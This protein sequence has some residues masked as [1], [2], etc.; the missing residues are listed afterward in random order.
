MLWWKWNSLFPHLESPVSFSACSSSVCSF[1]RCQAEELSNNTNNELP[2]SATESGQQGSWPRW[3][4]LSLRNVSLHLCH[5]CVCPAQ[6]W[7][8]LAELQHTSGQPRS[9]CASSLSRTVCSPHIFALLSHTLCILRN[10]CWYRF[11]RA[12]F[13]APAFQVLSRWNC[14]RQAGM[15]AKKK[16]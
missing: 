15:S 12:T 9:T 1:F 10:S 6:S 8:M 5:S 3:P 11:L 16:L 14:C 7:R 4:S 2:F 13:L